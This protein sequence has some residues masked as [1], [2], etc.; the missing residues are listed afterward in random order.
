MSFHVVILSARA[1]NLVP[2][3]RSVL[4]HD[5]EIGP[6]RIVVVDDGARACAE[7]ELPPVRWLSGIKPFVYARNV[8]LA[9]DAMETDVILLNDDGRLATPYG[10]TLLAGQV[11]RRPELGVCSAGI[12]GV[13]CNPRQAPTGRGELRAEPHM[14]AF[15]CVYLPRA[16][17]ARVGPLDERF[18]G[19]GFDDNDYCAR[20][21][22]HGLGIGIWDGCVV[23]HDGSA[24]ST[25]RTRPDVHSLF[26][27]NQRLFRQKWGRDS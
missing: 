5:P 4:A 2:C 24:P 9:V 10:F 17:Y 6:E 27:H 7:A 22:A 16:V 25:F 18:T 14:V 23:D 3:V 19:Y 1:A 20:V 12:R 26:T 13:V 11:E 15:V 21:L 8:N